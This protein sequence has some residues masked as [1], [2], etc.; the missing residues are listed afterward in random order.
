VSRVERTKQRLQ[1][2]AVKLFIERGYHNVTVEEIAR[3]AG[4]SHMT[5]FRHYPTKVSVLTDD[6]YDPVIG[7][8]VA[9]TDPALPPLERVR[10]GLLPLLAQ[11][12]EIDDEMMRARF[13][14]L[15]QN[16]DIVAHAWSNNRRTEAVIVEA[17][18]TTGVSALEARVAA[19]AVMGALTSA[20]LDWGEDD[21]SGPLRQRVRQT[22]E[23][24]EPGRSTDD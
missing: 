18:T 7:E 8:M 19:G 2:E 1:D 24:L 12:D 14:I 3:A 15:T 17:L 16:E 5:F 4:V 9:I 11:A 21:D 20:L 23:L 22:L 6:P 10:Q 13:R